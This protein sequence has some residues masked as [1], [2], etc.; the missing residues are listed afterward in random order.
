MTQKIISNIVFLIALCLCALLWYSTQAQF[1]SNGNIAW[2]TM[3]AERLLAGQSLSNHI[4]E[5]NP[6]L[7]VLIYIPAAL[8]GN[9]LAIPAVTVNTYLTFFLCCLSLLAVHHIIK[10]FEFLSANNRKSLL[11]GYFVGITTYA[12]LFFGDREHLMILALVPFVLCQICFIQKITVQKPLLLTCMIPGAALVLVKPH[13]GLIPVALMLERVVREKRIAS[14]FQADFWALTF[15]TILYGATLLIF[16]DDYLTV[17]FPDV[18]NLYVATY[19]TSSLMKLLQTSVVLFLA[20]ILIEVFE[21]DLERDKKTFLLRLYICAVLCLIP[22]IVQ[23]KGFYNHIIPA[24]VFF[25]IAMP[26]TVSF[27]MDSFKGNFK[28]LSLIIPVLAIAM[29]TNAINP[30]ILNFAKRSELPSLPVSEFL[31]KNC[32]KPCTFFAFHGDI[33][34]FN[35]TAAHLGYTHGTRFPSHWFIPGILR[36]MKNGNADE[37]KKG[38]RLLDKYAKMVLEDIKFYQPD[39]ILLQNN[40]DE[41]QGAVVDFIE[42]YKVEPEVVDILENDYEKAELFSFDRAQYFKGT[43]LE[44]EK[45]LKYDVYKKKTN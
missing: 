7:S 34:I 13:Y 42:T 33:E 23:F 25:T 10:K 29:L 11:V 22:F 36:K 43:K 41:D 15:S 2:L 16:F 21:K 20:F 6:P 17:I 1:M 8:L 18:F 38:R 27:R 37:K 24:Y 40:I 12:A 26:L 45:I 3:G 28:I 19:D 32:D 35:P 39:V 30:P 9:V 4:Y 44:K 31:D 14:F 5:T